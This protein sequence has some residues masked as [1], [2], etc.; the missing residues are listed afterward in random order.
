M[1][2]KYN[3][4]SKPHKLAMSYSAQ[5]RYETRK[6]RSNTGS[7]A[8]KDGSRRKLEFSRKYSYY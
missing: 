2:L 1:A 6:R 5:F 3:A 8:T 7:N 4:A